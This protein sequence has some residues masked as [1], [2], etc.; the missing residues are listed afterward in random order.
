MVIE[1]HNFD[2]RILNTRFER[3]DPGWLLRIDQHDSGDLRE[4]D[5][6]EFSQVEIVY[7]EKVADGFLRSGRQDQLGLRKELAR[8]KHRGETVEIRVTVRGDDVHAR[9]LAGSLQ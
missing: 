8:S 2:R 7:G 3:S 1:Y 5:V 6:F 4:V 9:I